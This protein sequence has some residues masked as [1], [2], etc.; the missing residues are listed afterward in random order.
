MPPRRSAPSARRSSC[1]GRRAMKELAAFWSLLFALL[2]ACFLSALN[3][4]G[5]VTIS[6]IDAASAAVFS[7]VLVMQAIPILETITGGSLEDKVDPLYAWSGENDERPPWTGLDSPL[8]FPWFAR[9]FMFR[10][11]KFVEEIHQ[12]WRD[13]GVRRWLVVEQNLVALA[14]GERRE[15][16]PNAIRSISVTL[17]VGTAIARFI[18]GAPIINLLGGGT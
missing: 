8:H 2:L 1:R 18:L 15:L 6:G 3:M 9:L 4:E 7:F 14:F 5:Y 11:H 13:I 16:V 10:K 12:E 17:L